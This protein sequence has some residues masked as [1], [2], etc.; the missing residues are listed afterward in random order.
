MKDW[1]SARE[2]AEEKLPEIPTTKSAVIR[3]AEREGWNAHPCYVRPRQGFGGGYEYHFHLL[4]TLAQIAYMRKHQVIGQVEAPKSAMPDDMSGNLTDRAKLERDARIAII[5]A[6]EKFSRGKRLSVQGSLF[7]FCDRYNMDFIGVEDWVKGF[8]PAI[9]QRS[10]FRW[11]S[12][13]KTQA[14]ALAH[15]PAAARKGSGL[16]ETANEG[17]VRAFIL[18]SIAANP[19][20]SAKHVRTYCR[21]E[22][23]DEIVDRYGEVKPMPPLR[24]FQHFIAALRQDEH[25]ALTK[26]T[27]PDRFR[28]HMQV[29]GN[30]SQLYTSEPN[31][32]WMI[33]ASP[34]DALCTDGRYSIYI[35]IDIATRRIVIFVSKTPRASAVGLLMRKAILILGKPS[36][37]KTDNG[38]DFTAHATKRLFGNLDIEIEVCPPYT[39]EQKGHV[40]RVIKTFQ[41]DFSVQVHGYIGHS[42]AERKAIEGRK[43]FDKRL[44]ASDKELFSVSMTAHELQAQI[45]EWVELVYHRAEHD[46]L[47]GKTPNAAFAASSTTIRRIDERALDVFLMPIAGRNGIR[48]IGKQGIRIG[49]HFYGAEILVGTEV[50]VRHDPNDIGRVVCF[51]IDTGEF[52]A[53]ATCP[54]LAGIHP[55]TFWSAQKRVQAD[56]IRDHVGPI[57]ASAKKFAK[58]P[59]GMARTLRVA[60]RDV[61][62]EAEAS[63]NVIQMPKREEVHSTPQIA[64]A[65]DALTAP[66]RSAEPKPLNE[67]AAKLHEAL[68]REAAFKATSK[69]I[70]LDPDASLSEAARKYKWAIALEARIA[71]GLP[72]DDGDAIK[73]VRFQG[74]GEYQTIKDCHRVF[75]LENAL[76]MN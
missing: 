55:Q 1:L 31:E 68:V 24:T 41:H 75:G 32:V 10:V 62:K 6:F 50:L 9:S 61:A 53:W 38:S 22:F 16:L 58:G 51:S 36:L 3:F 30:R 67:M 7:V 25:T 45:D 74:T 29:S 33:D 20:F 35:C 44:G 73:L 18:S 2:I 15:D 34:M 21:D 71:D 47:K 23:G 39:P 70:H 13:S 4:P 37:I 28:S 26:I 59:S 60:R 12:K 40:E 64:A 5:R 56:Y 11:M 65:L 43:S 46:G 57:A 66:Q 54:E 19:A 72:I 27:D 52:L 63:A 8:I 17:K 69:V 42:I 49:D 14:N 48:K 76:T